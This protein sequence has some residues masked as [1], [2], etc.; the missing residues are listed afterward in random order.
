VPTPKT[1]AAPWLSV[2]TV[3]P[4]RPNPCF[5]LNGLLLAGV[6]CFCLH[7]LPPSVDVA[8]I[9]KSGNEFPR[10]KLW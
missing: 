9:G 7:V 4:D 8:T 6:T 10:L 2:R 3:Q 5:V 1:Y